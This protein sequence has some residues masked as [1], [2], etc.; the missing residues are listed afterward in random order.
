M[1]IQT[2]KYGKMGER[3]GLG[4]VGGLANRA[5]E[6]H[7]PG[8][9]HVNVNEGGNQRQE[10]R[11]YRERQREKDGA[12]KDRNPG[13][14]KWHGGVRTCGRLWGARCW[15]P[16]SNRSPGGLEGPCPA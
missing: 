3:R 7:G 6:E 13:S 8:L 11:E 16:L 15:R 1:P 10:E 12:R 2:D 5:G 9:A 14:C 4:P